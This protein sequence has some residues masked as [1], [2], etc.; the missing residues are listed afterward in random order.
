VLLPA[1]ASAET[2]CCQVSGPC[3]AA[4]EAPPA[5][6]TGEHAAMP[7]HGP[8]TFSFLSHS[9][10]CAAASAPPNAQFCQSLACSRS[11]YQL[12]QAACKANGSPH[13]TILSDLTLFCRV[14]LT[15]YSAYLQPGWF[16]E[17]SYLW[18]VEVWYAYAIQ[19][20]TIFHSAT[21]ADHHTLLPVNKLLHTTSVL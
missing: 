17:D 2:L 9:Q 12:P 7:P 8:T 20:S 18:A 6:L 11:L 13:I 1:S 5:C 10:G 14:L 4:I 3:C 19:V 15:A 16:S 21:Q